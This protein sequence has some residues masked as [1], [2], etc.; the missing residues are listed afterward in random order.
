MSRMIKRKHG[1]QDDITELELEVAKNLTSLE[2]EIPQFKYMHI[3]KV[4]E[5]MCTSQSRAVLVYVPPNEMDLWKPQKTRVMSE[6]MKK[7]ACCVFIIGDYTILPKTPRGRVC[8][9]P[10]SRSLTAVHAKLL[11]DVVYPS[12]IIGRRIHYK[13]NGK[14]QTRIALHNKPTDPERLL[15]IR[16][17]YR[18]ITHKDVDYFDLRV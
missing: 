7:F 6:L 10:R 1:N 13:V 14:V 15:A 2:G 18:K 5:I 17:V 4:K 12:L 9:R 16:E 8:K 3:T 11:E